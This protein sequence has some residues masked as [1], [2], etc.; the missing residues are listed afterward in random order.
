MQLKHL[1]NPWLANTNKPLIN[2]IIVFRIKLMIENWELGFILNS[3]QVKTEVLLIFSRLHHKFTSW[4][5]INISYQMNIYVHIIHPSIPREPTCLN[6]GHIAFTWLATTQGTVT[7]QLSFTK[8]IPHSRHHAT[9]FTHTTS[10][11]LALLLPRGV[12]QQYALRIWFH[13]QK[14]QKVIFTSMVLEAN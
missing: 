12:T 7:G 2:C 5:T 3:C 14:V 8:H 6:T 1:P 11:I 10:L 9:C 4:I 13:L